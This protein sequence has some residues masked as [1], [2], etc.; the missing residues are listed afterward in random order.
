M[1]ATAS[2]PSFE[3]PYAE[4]DELLAASFLAGASLDVEAEARIDRLATRLITATR[5]HHPLIGGIEDLLREYSLS[6]EEGLALMV[7]AESLLRVPDDW[8]ADQL[9][10]DKLGS[11]DWSHHPKDSQ[12][13]LVFAAAWALGISARM[14]GK[15]PTPE[16]IAAGLAHRIG[17]SALRTVARK[18]LQLMGSH[19]VF[20][21][22]I[23]EALARASSNQAQ[24]DRY[25][26][27][28]L[29][30]G[31]RTAADAQRYFESYA[32]AIEAIG[33]SAGASALPYRLGISIKLSA[34]HPRYEPTSRP[35]VRAE[36]GPRIAE[37]ARLAKAYDLNFTIDAEEADRLELSLDLV[38]VLIA[39]PS[40]SGWDGFGLAVQAYQKRAQ[41]VIDHVAEVAHQYHRRLMIRLVKGAY[42]DTEIKRA[43]ERGLADYPVF[44]RKAMTDL[45]Y[46]ACAKKLLALRPRIYPQFASHNA[47]T[48]ASLVE[49]AGGRG[50][51]EFQRLH[52]MGEEL[53]TALQQEHL[54]L[55][56]RIYAPVGPHENLLA[57]LV[58]RLIE[59]GAN[60]SF[61][62][63]LS[64][65]HVPVA[66]LL[67]RPQ[68]LIGSPDQARAEKLPLPGDLQKPERALAAGIEFGDRRAVENLLGAIK[69]AE[70]LKEAM[71][72]I[73]GT[74]RDGVS[75]K[76]LSPIDGAEIGTVLECAPDLAPEAMGAARAGF[77]LWSQVPAD[78]R[79]DALD[80]ASH[81]IEAAAPRLL[82][83]L[84]TEAGKTL[85]DAIAEWRE[86]IDFCRYYAVEARRL[87]G[88]SKILPGPTGEDNRLV[89]HG[90]GVFLCI[91]PWNFPLSIFLGQISAALAAGNS[92][93]AKPA[94]QTPLIAAA[95]VEILH[96]ADIPQEALHLLPGDGAIGDKLVALPDIAGVAFTGSMET[97][98][99][100]QRRLATK[101]GPIPI[102]IAETGGINTMIADATALP[103][104][105]CDDVLASSF[106]S[107]GQRCSALR[108]LCI[109]EE[110]AD[111][112]ISMI[113]G[114]ARELV[115]GDPRQLPV[116]VGPVIDAE[117]KARLDAHIALM[118][119]SAIVHFAGEVKATAPEKGLYVAPHIFELRN[120]ADLE[121]E[122]FGPVLHVVRYKARDLDSLL[123]AIEAMGFGLTL[124]IHSRI[125]ATID[126]ILAR[127]LAGNCYV[128]RNM[129]GAVV[130]TQ[131]FGGFHRSGTG[132]KAGGPHYLSRFCLEQTIT[133]NT[134]AVGGNA[135]LINATL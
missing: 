6:S 34:L 116:H 94:E 120:V 73:S 103:E 124:G 62:A 99:R 128:N 49:L 107:A 4:K 76:L 63:L 27:D 132:P 30:E 29:G 68:E 3:A 33:K 98:A 28:M 85:D 102:L 18:T 88:T 50:G 24:S 54:D 11:G 8:T 1:S 81:R 122:V 111:R 109:Q 17:V 58:R 74:K 72:I 80:R 64:D 93:L 121:S 84:Q 69:A 48:V 39:D 87:L 55:A 40:L 67:T 130:G 21:Q 77:R 45:N 38:D 75:R 66:E 118:R 37:L 133:I 70:G 9:I 2:L 129:I 125:D 25:S 108:L 16:G 23:E 13:L 112:V 115:V 31:A 22:T 114:A 131:P 119:R 57:Y 105:L 51:F 95:T 101:E 52:G 10:E 14:F 61:V 90:R 32:Q 127:R 60:S 47:L 92:V 104:Q 126:K 46:L 44:S 83:L 71:P 117:A 96:Q 42:W 53:F 65:P 59:N 113:A 35:R 56:C 19:F 123:D 86:A 100:I 135:R 41:R 7:L 79:A 89:L 82:H 110:A 78:Q 12:A 20:G 134:A 106:R 91:S 15:G 43:Q 5:A 97:A 36:L 26:Y